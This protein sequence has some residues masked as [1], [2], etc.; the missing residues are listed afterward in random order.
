MSTTSPD[1]IL[2]L[3]G[4][5]GLIRLNAT[6][7]LGG[8]LTAQDAGVNAYIKQFAPS[9]AGETSSLGVLGAV[10]GAVISAGESYETGKP[11][12]YIATKAAL[13]S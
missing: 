11:A 10:V 3:H 12:G 13:P 1:Q 6:D 5:S 2:P 8:I 7:L 9:L 4:Q